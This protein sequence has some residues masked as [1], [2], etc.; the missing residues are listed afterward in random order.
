MLLF[1]FTPDRDNSEGNISL[2]EQGNIRKELWFDKPLY[3]AIT[4][5]L[6]HEYENCFRID[7]RRT[8]ADTHRAKG[9][10]FIY[11]RVPVRHSASFDN[12]LR[13]SFHKYRSPRDQRNALPSHT[14]TT[15][16]LLGLCYRFLRLAACHPWYFKF[17][18][19]LVLLLGIQHDADAGLGLYSLRRI[20]LYFR[21][22]HGPRLHS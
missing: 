2:L 9:R 1:D 7:Q 5:L 6:Y 4:C 16:I 18:T 3:E 10:A 13:D 12:T 19:T 15:T 14:S 20:L 11:R 17:L 22:V 8:T 21:N